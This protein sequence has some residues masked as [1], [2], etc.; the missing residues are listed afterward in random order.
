ML[1]AFFD[2]LGIVYAEVLPQGQSINLQKRLAT[3]DALN[4]REKKR[5]VRNEVMVTSS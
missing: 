1:I 2:V 4:E 3:S 5:T